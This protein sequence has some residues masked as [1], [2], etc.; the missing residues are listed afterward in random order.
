MSL[1]SIL[2]CLYQQMWLLG[3]TCL[4]WRDHLKLVSVTGTGMHRLT[5]GDIGQKSTFADL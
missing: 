5:D 1:R 2:L 4:P 3:L